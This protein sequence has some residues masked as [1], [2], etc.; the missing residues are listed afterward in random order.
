MKQ[1]LITIG[2]AFLLSSSIFGQEFVA[3]TNQWNVRFA[4]GMGYTTE[5]YIIEGDSVVDSKP[6]SKIWVSYDSLASLTYQG[7]LRE[8]LNVVYYMPP[9]GIEGILYDFNLEIGETAYVNN[10]F[11]NDI[12]ITVVDI[13]TIDY[14]GITRKRWHLGEGGE[15]Y[16]YWVEGI[17]SL[18]GPLHTKYWECIV[19]PVWA[20]LCFHND[21]ILSYIMPYETTC[22][23]STVGIEENNNKND[24]DVIPNPVKKGNDFHIKTNSLHGS[25]SL[26]NA[27]GQLI[28][29]LNQI[30]DKTITVETNNLQSGVYFIHIT[31]FGN[32]TTT[33]KL[34]VD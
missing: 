23:Q 16:E 25:L 13:D 20:L 15:V 26:F 29:R 6:Y 24:F 14:F 17:G 5:I 9:G 11:C 12:P 30:S 33:K 10:L 22:Y 31:S 32:R 3:P 18:N 1:Q 21:D 7:L 8:E 4:A 28:K 34:V 27:S 2:I 19:C